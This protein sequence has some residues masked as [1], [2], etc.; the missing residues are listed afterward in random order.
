MQEEYDKT[1]AE[2]SCLLRV[3]EH[4]AISI[5]V[6]E[7]LMSGRPVI[8]NQALPHWKT[9]VKGDVTAEKIV[10]AIKKTQRNGTV[11]Q[12]TSDYYR[13]RYDPAKYKGRLEEAA[14]SKWPEF[15]F[16]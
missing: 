10:K 7:F 13:D 11:P 1:I 8:S 3:P 9:L 2:C 5:S 12:E 6:A 15:T 4:D 14:R 16:G